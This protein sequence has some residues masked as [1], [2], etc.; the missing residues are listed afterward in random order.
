[1]TNQELVDSL[2]SF[3]DEFKSENLE[4]LSELYHDEVNFTDPIHQIVGL[5]DLK[6]Y[7]EHTMENVKYCHFAFD[8][9]LV[10]EDK[11]YL[12]WQMRFAHPKLADGGEI[13]LPGV[14]SLH[15]E[16]KKIRQQ[17]DH[18]DLGAMLYEHVPLVGYVIDKIKQRLVAE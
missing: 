4:Q 17:E 7:F 9:E 2:K 3:Y 14:S 6:A 15:F 16:D 12:S 11:A 1:M 5:D 10:G 8:D 13:V 18:Y